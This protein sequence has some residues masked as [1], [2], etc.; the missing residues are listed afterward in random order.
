MYDYS[1]GAVCDGLNRDGMNCNQGAESIVCFLMALSSLN[2]HINK[3]LN[4]I[5]QSRVSDEVN[6]ETLQKRKSFLSA[7]QLE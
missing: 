6:D 5:L 3:A 4:M 7:N 1:T 2:K